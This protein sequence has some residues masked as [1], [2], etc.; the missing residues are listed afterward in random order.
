MPNET[1]TVTVTGANPSVRTYSVFVDPITGK[2]PFPLSIP[3]TGAVAGTDTISAQMT[4][5]FGVLNS[6]PATVVWHNAP[7]FAAV[8]AVEEIPMPIL[9]TSVGAHPR[10]WDGDTV[11]NHP[12]NIVSVY[13]NDVHDR[14]GPD[15]VLG[16]GVYVYMSG[17]T[18]L[19]QYQ[20]IHQVTAI[21]ADKPYHNTEDTHNW[22]QFICGGSPAGL[23]AEYGSATYQTA[24]IDSVHVSPAPASVGSGALQLSPAG[25]IAGWTYPPSGDTQN[26]RLK[27]SS[28]SLTLNIGV[29]TPVVYPTYPYLPIYEGQVGKLYLYNNPSSNVFTFQ[30]YNGQPVDKT[31]A[32]S[33]V[34]QLSGNNGSWQGRLAISYDGSNFLLNYNGA[35]FDSHVNKTT[36]TIQDADIAWFNSVT[37]S[38]DMFVPTAGGGGEI[39]QIEVDYM[40]QPAFA[41]A[42]PLSVSADGASHVF[43]ISLTKPLSPQQ[44]GVNGTGNVVNTPTFTFTG[45]TVGTAVAILDGQGWLTGWT[46]P[47]TVPLSSSNS[48]S[49]LGTSSGVTGTLT[50]LVNDAFVTGPVTYIAAGAIATV[51]LV[52]LGYTAPTIS[53]FSVSPKSGS[54]PSYSIVNGA[55]ETLTATVSS[56]FNNATTC[57]FWRQQHGTST[58]V[59]MG[60]GTLSSSYTS[61]GLYY[62]V[63]TFTQLDTTWYVSNDLGAQATDTVSSLQSNLYFDSSTY[64]MAGGSGGGG[65]GGGCFT[66]AVALQTAD[67]LVKFGDLPTNTP[68][69]IT[70][71]TGTHPAELLVHENYEGLMI[72]LEEGKLVTLDHLMKMA[73]GSWEAADRKYPNLPRVWFKGTVYNLRVL[74]NNPVDWHFIL[75]NGDV[76]HNNKAI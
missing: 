72:V 29:V 39:F 47:I 73:D 43:T 42:S 2:A 33:P 37:K 56:A 60:N 13:Y 70:N 38:F 64:A 31:V 9:Q 50:R 21:G 23:Y 57:A 22:F 35:T 25:G 5:T 44:Q 7:S 67:G 48:S 6:N 52:G 32:A 24:T 17:G 65:G 1:V 66:V 74:S 75:W 36:L 53:A 61:G 41:S 68:F 3:L 28:Y 49:T 76:A 26:W 15:P 27:N 18:L 54:A 10:P 40:V 45:G 4:G 34:F 71:E 46:V 19:S 11:A 58:R 16:P 20:G 59:N 69:P 30:T 62:K 63:F 14:P 12:G 8:P 55:T 51:S